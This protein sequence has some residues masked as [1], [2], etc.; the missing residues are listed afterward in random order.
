MKVGP[1]VDYLVRMA[2]EEW[3]QVSGPEL[4]AGS[5]T[6]TLQLLVRVAFVP[7]VSAVAPPWT[8]DGLPEAFDD[9]ATAPHARVATVLLAPY[10]VTPNADRAGTTDVLTWP[11]GADGRTRVVRYVTPAEFGRFAV[12]L[13]RLTG[14]AGALRP[15]TRVSELRRYDVVGFLEREIVPAPWLQ[16]GHAVQLGRAD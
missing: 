15:R 16:P 8:D 10:S 13:D 2:R 9:I 4:Y 7:D 6:V 14:I 5:F 3:E 12:D 1:S 11:A